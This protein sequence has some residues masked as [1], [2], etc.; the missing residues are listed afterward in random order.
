[1]EILAAIFIGIGV[2]ELYAWLPMI[3]YRLLERAIQRLP[4][5]YHERCREEWKAYLDSLPNTLVRFVHGCSYMVS[6]V[7]IYRDELVQVLKRVI[8]LVDRV[9]VL[10]SMVH[11]AEVLLDKTCEPEYYKRV[12]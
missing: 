12:A 2:V 11:V 1:M 7:S 4:E 8:D 6:Y 5:R 9:K 10:V 3:T